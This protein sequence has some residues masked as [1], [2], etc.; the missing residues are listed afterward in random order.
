MIVSFV[1][2]SKTYRA[3]NWTTM[4]ATEN[5]KKKGSEFRMA[6]TALSIFTSQSATTCAVNGG[7]YAAWGARMKFCGPWEVVDKEN[8]VWLQGNRPQDIGY[9]H[10]QAARSQGENCNWSTHKTQL[11]WTVG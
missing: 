4:V 5:W 11:E 9:K 3:A 8:A 2:S 7:I 1:I 10:K 6:P